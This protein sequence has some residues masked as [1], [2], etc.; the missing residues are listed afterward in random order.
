MRGVTIKLNNKIK[1]KSEVKEYL[2]PQIIYIPLESKTGVKY[3]SLVKEED[4][5]FKGD[6]VALNEKINFP[7]HSSVS[8]YV[9]KM[10]N[11]I[12][13]NGKKVKCLVI[14]NDFKER[15][16]NKKG[17]IDNINNYTKDE[18]IELLRT[19]GI[20]G[21]GGSDFPTFLKYTTTKI[22]KLLVNAVEC[23]PYISCDKQISINYAEEILEAIDALQNIVDIKN[24][25]VVIKESNEEVIKAFN[26]YI[27]TYPNIKVKLVPNIY[28][29][30]WE[31]NV[32]ENVLHTTYN[33]YP[34]EIGAVVQN[35]STM[36]AIYEMLKLSSPLT[37]RIITITGPGINNP[38]N[39]KVKIGSLLSEIIENI[40]GYKD[41]EKPLFIAGGPMMGSSL[42]SDELV[43]T[44]DLNCVL[45]ID[46]KKENNY[47]CISCGKCIEVCPT[48]LLPVLIMKNF[49]NEKE[50]KCLSPNKC[51]ECGLCSYV[52]PSKIEVREYV[53]I[54]KGK[55]K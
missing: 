14:E 26:K 33:K 1:T 25:Y 46:D 42:P 18:Y 44:K 36:Y 39:V 41:I 20:T 47:P 3:K 10:A 54:A 8:G 31:R 21:L 55:V 15:Y 30:G 16:K 35:V 5:V 19:S 28:P 48:H 9:I 45:V 12:M 53:R 50:L 7:I 40:D 52:C 29:A 24:A 49:N 32:V 22:K 23:E 4:Y 27:N 37:E 43:V 2:K 11:K 6:V 13:N 38:V 51:I 17:K 34:T